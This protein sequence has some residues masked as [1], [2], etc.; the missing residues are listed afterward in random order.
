ML[1]TYAVGLLQAKAYRR[2]KNYLSKQLLEFDLTMPQWAFLGLVFESKSLRLS[3]IAEMME[4]EAPFATA[5]A[6]QMYNK[7]FINRIEDKV[8]RRAKLISLTETGKRLV[9]NVEK[10]IKNAMRKIY[11]NISQEELGVYIKVLDAITTVYSE[12][13]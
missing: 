5:I 11:K 7:G 4:V 3:Y 1:Q 6:D 9:P 2:L 13:D 8:D 10:G 12:T